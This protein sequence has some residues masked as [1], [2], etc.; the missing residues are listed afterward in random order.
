MNPLHTILTCPDRSEGTPK[1]IRHGLFFV[2]E[3]LASHSLPQMTRYV[4]AAGE[5][6]LKLFIS[7]VIHL[8]C[9]PP[10]ASSVGGHIS[11]ADFFRRFCS[12]SC[13]TEEL[14]RPGSLRSHQ[15]V[16]GCCLVRAITSGFP[17]ASPCILFCQRDHRTDPDIP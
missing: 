4:N 6:F 3:L 5:Q 1:P 11:I 14:T 2:E 17:P 13:C 16:F 10:I 8:P 12:G 7:Q 9:L 15:N